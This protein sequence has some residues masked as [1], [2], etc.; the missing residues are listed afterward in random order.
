MYFVLTPENAQTIQLI[1]DHSCQKAHLSGLTEK[2]LNTIQ[3][4]LLTQIVD[5]P[6]RGNNILDLAFVSDPSFVMTFT[7]FDCLT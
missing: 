5:E 2:F 1:Y 4:N 7:R 3:D 6:T